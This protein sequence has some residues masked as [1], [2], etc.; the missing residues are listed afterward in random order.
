MRSN[1]D[2]DHGTLRLARQITREIRQRKGQE[3]ME[4]LQQPAPLATEREPVTASIVFVGTGTKQPA[5]LF[6]NVDPL[7]VL[8][9]I[10]QIEEGILKVA[11]A[12]ST[13]PGRSTLELVA[14][15]A[16]EPISVATAYGLSPTQR[17]AAIIMLRLWGEQMTNRF[18]AAMMA[19]AKPP[20][21]PL[22]IP[23]H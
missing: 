22:L 7:Q 13:V 8:V 4:A 11:K 23:R 19:P 5:L 12:D 9:A 17:R 15:N 6:T 2:R 18:L 10:E 14:L 20:E 21:S 1:R 16:D 3:L